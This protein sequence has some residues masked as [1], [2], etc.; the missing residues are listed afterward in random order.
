LLLFLLPEG[1]VLLEELDDGLGISEGFLVD[2]IN[3]LESVRQSLF[4]K[5]TCL[6]V[7]VHNFVVEHGEVESQ[8]QSD[9]VASVEGL[10]SRLGELIVL[11]GTIFDSLEFVCGGALS[12]IS[13]IITDHFVEEGLGLISG[14]N[15][16]AGLL[17][18]L[19]NTDALLVKLLLDLL[20]VDRKTLLEFLVFWILLDGTNGSYSGSLGANLVLEP[21]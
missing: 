21:N 18:D 15:L 14:G 3:L 5:F 8:S 13:V 20:L 4:T 2:V 19:N 16:H 11:E 10:R 1:K 12:N 7:V 6:L 17:D 9:W